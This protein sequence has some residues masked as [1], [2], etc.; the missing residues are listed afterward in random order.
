VAKRKWFF[1]RG[2]VRLSWET[3]PEDVKWLAI[4]RSGVGYGY[5]NKPVIAAEYWK[6]ALA[7][8]M[9]LCSVGELCFD[10]KAL[11]FER[12]RPEAALT[13]VGFTFAEALAGIESLSE[14]LKPG[15]PVLPIITADEWAAIRM[16][17]PGAEYV[18][19]DERGLVFA[20]TKYPDKWGN[21]WCS[22]INCQ[23]MVV[24][25]LKNRFSPI[26]WRDSLVKYEPPQENFSIKVTCACGEEVLVDDEPIYGVWTKRTYVIPCP[27]CHANLKIRVKYESAS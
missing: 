13:A 23:C 12:P 15:K 20:Y 18:A 21:G 11:L 14:L 27:N 6:G 24:T 19:K 17:L 2:N 22:S 3:L 10:W 5:A 8:I 25:S 26:P 7:V 9:P 1:K 16:L 4:D